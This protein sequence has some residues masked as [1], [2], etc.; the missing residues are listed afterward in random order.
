VQP[1]PA[2][3]IFHAVDLKPN[4]PPNKPPPVVPLGV[5]VTAVLTP[6]VAAAATRFGGRAK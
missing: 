3:T 4:T 6:C 5:L 1:Q 2:P